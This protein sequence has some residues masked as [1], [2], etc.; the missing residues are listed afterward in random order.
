MSKLNKYIMQTGGG[1]LAEDKEWVQ[2][3]D[4]KIGKIENAPTHD[5]GEV[6]M[7]DFVKKSGRGKGGVMVDNVSTVLSAT[8]ENRRQSDDSYTYKDEEIKIKPKEAQSIAESIGFKIKKQTK[9]LSPAK[10]LDLV[11][12]SKQNFLSKFDKPINQYS[13]E[14]QNSLR[15]NTAIIN[16]LPTDEDLYNTIFG[17]QESKKSDNVEEQFQYGG[18]PMIIQ[19]PLF[20]KLNRYLKHV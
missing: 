4:G 6:V 15:A 1:V 17:I 7:G 11:L 14:G 9:G 20:N 13:I 12:E 3:G 2:F 5:D 16:S 18:E 8:H 10:L 19:K